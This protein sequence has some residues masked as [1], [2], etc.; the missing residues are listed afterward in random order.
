MGN[1]LAGVVKHHWKVHVLLSM[2]VSIGACI[3]QISGSVEGHGM[4][5][6]ICCMRSHVSL[7]R[8]GK[9]L[10]CFWLRMGVPQKRRFG[11]PPNGIYNRARAILDSRFQLRL[12]M[13]S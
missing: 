11:Q 13:A 1:S 9:S 12:K 5:I 10:E 8:F 2:W 3:G 7:A 6:S 4:I